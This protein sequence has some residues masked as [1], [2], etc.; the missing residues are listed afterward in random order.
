MS[1]LNEDF[2]TAAVA[3]FAKASQATLDA[4]I[5]I[6]YRDAQSGIQIMEL[7]DGRQFQINYLPKSSSG[8]HYEIVRELGRN[9]A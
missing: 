4:G 6:F 9:A 1:L 5:P 2:D 7:P 8:N 3:A